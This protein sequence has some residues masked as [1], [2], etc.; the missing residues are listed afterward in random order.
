VT[1]R[2][3]WHVCHPPVHKATDPGPRNGFPERIAAIVTSRSQTACT[4]SYERRRL[5]R[6][7]SISRAIRHERD[8]H[9]PAA[10][11]AAGQ[12][13]GSPL[14]LGVTRAVHGQEWPAITRVSCPF[15]RRRRC[16]PLER[17]PSMPIP[18]AIPGPAGDDLSQTPRSTTSTR[19]N[20]GVRGRPENRPPQADKRQDRRPG[21]DRATGPLVSCPGP[22]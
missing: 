17:P 13:C 20:D 9:W 16:A 4:S 8:R 18:P 22:R 19:E 1:A 6:R 15:G 2:G 5:R 10:P 21:S 3:L 7:R 14:H 11:G 12:T